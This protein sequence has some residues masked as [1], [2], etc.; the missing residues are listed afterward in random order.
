MHIQAPEDTD[1]TGTLRA[2]ALGSSGQMSLKLYT[3][4]AV[5]N[6]IRMMN[7]AQGGEGAAT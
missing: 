5:L 4:R 7:M 1:A 2:R 3:Q 6:R